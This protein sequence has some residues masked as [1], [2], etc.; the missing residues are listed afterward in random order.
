MTQT[1]AVP[2]K[3]MQC[4]KF[5]KKQ[6]Y[7]K[8]LKRGWGRAVALL[9]L[10]ICNTPD[11]ISSQ[12]KGETMPNFRKQRIAMRIIRAL[13]A[14]TVFGVIGLLVWR[15]Y[16][17]TVMPDNIAQLTQNEVLEAA[18]AENGGAL[19][20][21]YQDQPTV[22]RAEYNYGYFSVPEYVY[23]PEAKQ[24]QVVFRYNNGT[25]ANVAKDYGLA[26]TPAREEELF[27]GTLVVTTDL[28]PDNKEDNFDDAATL[29]KQRIM[30]T[31]QIREYT[32]LYTY[33]RYVFDGVEVTDL[34]DAFYFDIYYVDDLD[35]N[36]PAYGT[37]LLYNSGEEW[38]EKKVK[39]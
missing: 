18:Q 29:G 12:K 15:V 38:M 9:H 24:V 3:L 14:L 8:L 22:T 21:V 19:S 7:Q 35:Y 33:V 30:P 4:N 6:I 37:L 27:D 36:E 25:L 39:Q 20:Y 11:P 1:P 28:T 31:S 13:T 2:Q 23:I 16:F 32:A 26:Q 5:C 34:T 10:C 17:S